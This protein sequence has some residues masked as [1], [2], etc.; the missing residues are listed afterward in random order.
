MR[1][2]LRELLLASDHLYVQTSE[3]YPI[4]LSAGG[5]R[6]QSGFERTGEPVFKAEFSQAPFEGSPAV[7]Q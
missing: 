4:S 5:D 6:S 1:P 3:A 7:S 2:A